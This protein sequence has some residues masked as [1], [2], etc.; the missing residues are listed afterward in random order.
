MH[1]S[2][3][4]VQR[5]IDILELFGGQTP[6]LGIT[7]IVEA[8]GLHKSTAAGLVYTLE[9]NG[10][11]EQNPLNCKY[12]LGLKLVERAFTVLDQSDVRNIALLY[13]QTLHEWCG[14]SV[15][16]G[17]PE[18]RAHCVHR[19]SGQH[20][21]TRFERQ[22]RAALAGPLHRAGQGHPGLFASCA[23]MRHTDPVRHAH[24][25]RAHIH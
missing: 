14:E 9:R 15:Q 3:G 1:R 18:R 20:S 22:D 12:R 10:F 2:I 25:Y 19:S 24:P 16:P 13:L 7:E 17:H 21:R 5:A 8:R 11:L 23:G 4:S 6:E